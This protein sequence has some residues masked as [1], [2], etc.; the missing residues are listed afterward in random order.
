MK[1][2]RRSLL[3]FF[4]FTVSG[5]F[6]LSRLLGRPL[7]ENM[8]GGDVVNVI[9]TVVGFGFAILFLKEYFFGSRSS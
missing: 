8:T 7:F 6:N 2:R 4:V 1:N 3:L 9:G 5:G